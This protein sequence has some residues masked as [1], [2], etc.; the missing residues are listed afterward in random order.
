MESTGNVSLNYLSKRIMNL[1]KEGKIVNRMF[2]GT[3]YFYVAESDIQD[4]MPS[5]SGRQIQFTVLRPLYSY[6]ETNLYNSNELKG[7]QTKIAVLKLFVLE[8]VFI[9]K[10]N[11]KLNCEHSS[12]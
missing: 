5:T 1:E 9:I 11:V 3:D 6:D 10:Q 8:E 12:N 2:T 7:L 4:T